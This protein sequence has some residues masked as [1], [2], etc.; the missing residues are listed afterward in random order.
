[1][2][3][4]DVVLFQKGLIQGHPE[5]PERDLTKA[6]DQFKGLMEIYPGSTLSIAGEILIHAFKEIE[7]LSDRE[8][9]LPCAYEEI[10]SLGDKIEE[11]KYS[12]Y[13]YREKINRQDLRI[14]ALSKEIEDLKQQMEYFKV[15]DI[16]MDQKK[17][18]EITEP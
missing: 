5:N 14:K 4:T 2:T 16:N 13:L 6:E 15:I 9:I 12:E 11:K 1:M 18:K 8:E 17:Q 7:S 3:Q 10:E